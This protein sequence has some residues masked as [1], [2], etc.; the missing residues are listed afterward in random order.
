MRRLIPEKE[1]E[2]QFRAL[3]LDPRAIETPSLA[4]AHA[5]REVLRMADLV[6]GMVRDVKP[7]F[8]AST[9]D[10]IQDLEARDDRVDILDREIKFYLARM[11]Q[12]SMT[13][14][15]AQRELALVSL[16]TNLENIADVVTKNL[17]ELAKKKIARGR[18]F[19][20][21]GWKDLC[22]F[23]ERIFENYD[24]SIAA[25]SSGDEE[26]A[27][28]V[29]RVRR[30]LAELE[31]SLKQSHLERLHRGLRESFETSSLHLEILSNMRRINS[32]AS[33]FARWSLPDRGARFDLGTSG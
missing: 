1:D 8:E 11:L 24:L 22:V 29:L 9:P 20:D 30:E 32:Y 15:Q 23:F 26:L 14:E 4:L 10:L 3:Y 6:R 21:E 18:H 25:F 5:M 16:T 31:L 19:S 28:R 27:R 17:L 33:D 7:V 13:Q 12:A 2:G